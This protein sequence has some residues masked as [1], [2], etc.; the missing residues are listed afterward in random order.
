LKDKPL[1]QKE[2][3]QILPALE[4]KLTEL[5]E[6]T[7]ASAWTDSTVREKQIA[8]YHETIQELRS[9][10]ERIDAHVSCCAN[11]CKGNETETKARLIAASRSWRLTQADQD[12]I[13]TQV[14]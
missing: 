10:N 14:R 13:I 2:W 1:N 9:F 12:V 6:R 11:G 7:P 5:R 4:S 8:F 3:G